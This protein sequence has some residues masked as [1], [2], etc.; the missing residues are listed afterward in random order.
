MT[1]LLQ[2]SRMARILAVCAILVL[3]I[4]MAGVAPWAITIAGVILAGA[5]V[6]GLT[7][8]TPWLGL[9]TRGFAAAL[10]LICAPFALAGGITEQRLNALEPLRE[11]APDAYL[12]AVRAVSDY[13]WRAALAELRP[14]EHAALVA[15]EAQAAAERKERQRTEAATTPAPTRT[16]RVRNADGFH[17][18][19]SWDGSHREFQRDVRNRMREPRSFEHIQTRVTRVNE[20]GFHTVIME[21]RARNGFGGMNVATALGRYRNDTCA[22]TLVSVG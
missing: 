19:S 18:L 22:H 1:G 2:R 6:I 7:R 20:A 9:P 3:S 13:R 11:T 10:L 4:G 8:P 5:G 17:C 16:A 21:Y 12:E 14:E 15:A